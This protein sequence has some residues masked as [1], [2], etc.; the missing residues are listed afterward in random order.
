VH[1]AGKLT[2]DEIRGNIFIFNVAG[3]DTTANT[4]AYAFALLAINPEIQRWVMEEIDQYFHGDNSPNYEGTYPQLKRIMAVMV[5]LSCSFA[6]YSAQAC[7]WGCLSQS[8]SSH[9][10]FTHLIA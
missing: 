10:A 9:I 2:D 7:S 5:S 3:H 8:T 6:T 1:S 4:L